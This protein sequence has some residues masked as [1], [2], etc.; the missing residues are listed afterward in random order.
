MTTQSNSE[1]QRQAQLNQ[2]VE[3]SEFLNELAAQRHCV[4][5]AYLNTSTTFTSYAKIVERNDKLLADIDSLIRDTLNHI[6][7]NDLVDTDKE[8]KNG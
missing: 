7:G 2:V 1:L 8:N 3:Y 6:E 5:K 4:V